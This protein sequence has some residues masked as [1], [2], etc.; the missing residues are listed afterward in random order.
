MLSGDRVV[1]PGSVV[2]HRFPALYVLV[3]A[4]IAASLLSACATYR[5]CGLTGCEGDARITASV[6]TRLREN[7]AIEEWGIRVQTLDRVVYLYGLVDTSLER[8]II[9]ATVLEVPGVARVVDSIAIRGNT[10]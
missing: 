9:E 3:P 4:A 5:K 1:F 7:R 6:E 10:W 8:S 2:R